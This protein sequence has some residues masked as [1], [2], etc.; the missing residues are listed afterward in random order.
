MLDLTEAMALDY[1]PF[2]VRIYSVAPGAYPATRCGANTG[3]WIDEG[4]VQHLDLSNR[5]RAQTIAVGEPMPTLGGSF[6]DSQEVADRILRC[7]TGEVRSTTRP[8]PTSRC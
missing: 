7:V 2:G 5:L 4:G 1:K 3:K 6:A 8:A